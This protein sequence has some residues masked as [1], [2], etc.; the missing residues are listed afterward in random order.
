M[1]PADVRGLSTLSDMAGPRKTRKQARRRIRDRHCRWEFL[2][3]AEDY[4][5]AFGEFRDTYR[6]WL[7]CR[8]DPGWPE[9]L[10]A[11]RGEAPGQP[12]QDG[13]FILS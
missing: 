3:R 1:L 13:F 7:A 6:G 10:A 2:R 12:G 11:L 5:Q 9:K 4:V 8:L